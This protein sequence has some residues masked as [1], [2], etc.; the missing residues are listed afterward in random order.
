MEFIISS[1][2]TSARSVMTACMLTRQYSLRDCPG[3]KYAAVT[4]LWQFWFDIVK[5][6]RLPWEL[7]RLHE[8]YG[9]HLRCLPRTSRA[10]RAETEQVLSFALVRTKS[11]SPTRTS[12]INCTLH[13]PGRETE[14]IG[15]SVA[16][17]SR[18]PYC[19][20]RITIFIGCDVPP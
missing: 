17:V 6:G 8:I 4:S 19:V 18:M 5:R 3:P 15:K 7:K 12:M 11:M 1:T 10:L 14:T 2:C 13:H 9:P 16:S 20:A